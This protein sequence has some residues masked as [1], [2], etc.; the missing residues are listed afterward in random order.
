MRILAK[1]ASALFILLNFSTSLHALD[2]ELSPYRKLSNLSGQLKSVGS[3]TLAHEMKL[4]ADGFKDLYP[5]VAIDIESKG[6][7]TA[8][9]ALLEGRA[10]LAPMS[11]QM[12]PDEI[13]LFQTKYGYKPTAV[14]VAIDA[15]AIFVNKE[16]PLECISMEQLDRV[17]SSD[18][19]STS[20]PAI[21][22]WGELGLTGEWASKPIDLYGRN[23]LSGTY[24]FFK[25]N[26]LAGG[27]YKDSLKQQDGSEAVVKAVENDKSAIGYSSVGYKSDNVR[28]VPVTIKGQCF[29]PS[30]DNTYSRK[31]PLARGLY[32]Y[33]LKN[34]NAAID[35]LSGEFIKYI[36]SKDG[37]NFAK[38]AGYYPITNKIRDHELTRLGLLEP[39]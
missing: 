19:K 27:D 12:T 14:L 4:W 20:Q 11:R 5:N 3:D 23:T 10:Q 22:T 38:L 7:N 9:P 36:L 34:P 25:Q 6:S 8:P 2:L 21:H 26:V 15:L 30:F 24:K 18:H 13:G 32:V 33:I 28:V 16:N 17:F 39:K 37:Q 31:Y 29:D 35:V 1:S